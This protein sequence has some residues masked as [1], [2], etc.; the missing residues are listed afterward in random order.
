MEMNRIALLNAL[1]KVL[2]RHELL[3]REVLCQSDDFEEAEF[4]EPL[5]V[6]ANLGFLAVENLEGLFGVGA[7]VLRDLFCGQGRAQLILIGRVAE[8]A[9]VVAD[10]E[11]DVVTEFLKLAQLAHG[12]GV[13]DVQ[14]AGAGVVATVYAQGAAL[15]QPV[16]QLGC[17]IAGGL[18]IAVFRA[19]HQQGYLLV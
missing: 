9:G 6:E 7:G 18:F 19:L 17:H 13:S 14:V 8:Q 15:G 10:Q 4:T 11:D 3:H 2:A 1:R 16:A 5:G 12:D